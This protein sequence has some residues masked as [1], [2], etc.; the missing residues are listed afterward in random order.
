MDRMLQSSL[1]FRDAVVGIQSFFS[2]YV[3]GSLV[4]MAVPYADPNHP[5]TR[6]CAFDV[7]DY[8]GILCNEVGAVPQNCAADS[9][10]L[11]RSDL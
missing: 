9:F 4:E 5:Y 10:S 11:C 1:L 6:K 3:P 8:V 7:G 2:S